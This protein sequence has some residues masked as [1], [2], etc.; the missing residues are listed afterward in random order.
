MFGG[1]VFNYRRLQE[2]GASVRSQTLQQ[3]LVLIRIERVVSC[4]SF[5]KKGWFLKCFYL[6][7]VDIKTN[8]MINL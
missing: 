8:Q 5:C 7:P 2:T 6:R 1:C 3:G 4:G